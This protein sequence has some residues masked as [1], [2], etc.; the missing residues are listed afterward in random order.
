MTMSTLGKD[1]GEKE[2]NSNPDD[3]ISNAS[4]RGFY[5][6]DRNERQTKGKPRAIP[7]KNMLKMVVKKVTKEIQNRISNFCFGSKID[8]KMFV[9]L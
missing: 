7:Y 2:Q 6:Q 4:A 1:A 5:H 9:L 8:K 3:R